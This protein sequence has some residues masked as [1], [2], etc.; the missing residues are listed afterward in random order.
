MEMLLAANSS[1][2]LIIGGGKHI[3]TCSSLL[4]QK[5]TAVPQSMFGGDNKHNDFCFII[6]S[7]SSVLEKINHKQ[8]LIM[9][10]K[11]R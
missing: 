1:E 4:N 3:I 2:C 6:A 10:H 11:G 9:G 7:G 5:T 8:I